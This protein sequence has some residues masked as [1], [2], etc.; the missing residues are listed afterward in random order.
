ME[1]GSLFLGGSSLCQIGERKKKN[2][3]STGTKG[4]RSGDASRGRCQEHHG[5][6]ESGPENQ[7]SGRKVFENTFSPLGSE[8]IAA[9][10]QG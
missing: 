1:R 2:L 10:S 4:E 9:N 8:K 7:R 6:I 5:A 3:A